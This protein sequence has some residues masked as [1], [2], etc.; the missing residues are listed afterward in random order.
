MVCPKCG[1][2]L[3]NNSVF[4]GKCGAKSGICP[5]CNAPLSNGASFCGN[6]GAQIATE[7][8]GQDTNSNNSYTN[9][10]FDYSY[11][12]TYQTQQTNRI[13]STKDLFDDWNQE[14]S[15]NKLLHSGLPIII[16][17]VCISVLVLI[18]LLNKY[19]ILDTWFSSLTHKTSSIVYNLTHINIYDILIKIPTLTLLIEKVSFLASYI[20]AFVVLIHGVICDGVLF[21]IVFSKWCKTNNIPLEASIKKTLDYDTNNLIFNDQLKYIH[22]LSYSIQCLIHQHNSTVRIMELIDSII[23]VILD[24]A[25]IVF[26]GAYIKTDWLKINGVI[27]SI[28]TIKGMLIISFC[29]LT[30]SVIIGFVFDKIIENEKDNWV[31]V[32]LPDHYIKYKKFYEDD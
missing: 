31:R 28:F 10:D 13:K 12:S 17:F 6:C 24:S 27:S 3:P 14:N 25:L 26:V 15:F 19:I 20:M 29:L 30:I 21:K 22:S 11:S 7:S 5:T 4:C 1:N 2:I 9:Q 32:N 16:G 18:H 23:T 8:G